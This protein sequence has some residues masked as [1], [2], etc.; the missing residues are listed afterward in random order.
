M[1]LY[2][3]KLKDT[4]EERE[5]Q[6]YFYAY[7]DITGV[8][9]Y[10]S[11][12]FITADAETTKKILQD[13]HVIN[14]SRVAIE[15]ARRRRTGAER[16]SYA[17]EKYGREGPTKPPRLILEHVPKGVETEELS[18]FVKSQGVH[19]EYLKILASGDALVEL[20]TRELR[21][22]AIALL[23]G[24]SFMEETLLARVG[25]KKTMQRRESRPE[26]FRSREEEYP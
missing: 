17:R 14:G 6:E 24:K 22:R 10:S 2:I 21:D 16:V 13:T 23:D 15:P 8:K 11:F 1:Q 3:G 4:T 12:G 5:V 25:R 18:T 26:E 19:P 20:G 9:L 7:G